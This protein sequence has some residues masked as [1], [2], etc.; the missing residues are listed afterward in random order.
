MNFIMPL[1]G[2]V[3]IGLAVTVMLLFNGR[4]T[5]ISGIVNGVL[6]RHQN[7]N[8]WRWLFIAGL[9]FGG[10][11]LKIFLPQSFDMRLEGPVYLPVIGGFLVGFGSRYAGGCTSGHAI[12]GL[13]DLQL[14]SL[15]A[16]IGFFIGGL[17]MTYFILP[18]IF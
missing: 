1:A 14:P 5:G 18:I 13:S 8:L 7:K 16:V 12:S 2:G 4:I 10:L 9:I 3:L 17:A 11:I 15:I 6:E